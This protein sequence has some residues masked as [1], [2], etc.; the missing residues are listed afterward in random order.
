VATS[1]KPSSPESKGTK[2]R[3]FSMGSIPIVGVIFAVVALI[4]VAAVVFTGGETVDVALEDEVGSPAVEGSLPPF[5]DPASDT[6]IGTPSPSVSGV[7]FADNA[8]A[9]GDDGEPK[10]IVFL[11]HWC[12]HCQE[13]VPVVQ[14]WLDETGGVDGVTMYSVATSMDPVRP[15]WPPSAWLEEEGWTVPVIRDDELGTT[16]ASYGGTAFPFWVFVNSDGTVAGRVSGNIPIDQL[17]GIMT[18]LT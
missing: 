14:E 1:T 10:A 6:T 16:L 7:D 11:A 2:K 9:I 3:S 8:V 17:E 18:S 5:S 4:L 15:N 12:P 13:E